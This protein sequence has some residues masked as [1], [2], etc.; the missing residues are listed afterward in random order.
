M[1][2]KIRNMIKKIGVVS[3][4]AAVTGV[5][6]PVA[7]SAF[8]AEKIYAEGDV[9][10]NET[11]F[12]DKIFREYVSKK[13]D[14]DSN[15]KLSDIE[16][17]NVK[18]I[19]GVYSDNGDT[20]TDL[21]GIEYFEELDTLSCNSHGLNSL[22]VSKNK[23]LK[24]LS[25]NFNTEL[26][27]LNISNNTLLTSLS[28]YACAIKELN[29]SNNPDLDSLMCHMNFLKSLDVSENNKL[30][31][32]CCDPDLEDLYISKNSVVSLFSMSSIGVFETIKS[33]NNNVAAVTDDLSIKGLDAG[34]STI[35][36]LDASGEVVHNI[37]L[38]VK[39]DNINEEIHDEDDLSAPDSSN[40]DENDET[41]WKEYWEAEKSRRRKM[42]FDNTMSKYAG[43]YPPIVIENE[44][45]EN[46]TEKTQIELYQIL[47]G[48]EVKVDS[49]IKEDLLLN[50]LFQYEETWTR[51]ASSLT[52]YRIDSSTPGFSVVNTYGEF[53][54]APGDY[55]IKCV[56]VPEGYEKFKD[57]KFT[58]GDKSININ[59]PVRGILQNIKSNGEKV[60]IAESNPDYINEKVYKIDESGKLTKNSDLSKEDVSMYGDITDSYELLTIVLGKKSAANNNKG[61]II[62]ANTGDNKSTGLYVAAGVSIAGLATTAAVLQKKRKNN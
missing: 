58:L 60:Y 4:L 14:K 9:E 7:F 48:K 55:V 53:Y 61:G 25:C 59:N 49:F 12:P 43:G 22:D 36:L 8:S 32:I 18:E 3:V 11:N 33:S 51:Y 27:E 44:S 41:Y 42:N 35:S 20:A 24:E 54:V 19:S 21:K 23:K 52:H 57:I 45:G 28:C 6:V 30:K 37:L 50:R 46:L 40:I 16:R 10:I 31:T 5:T 34:E 29:L 1:K 39:G 56:K 26:T 2:K 62:S 15:N 38:T 17:D 13:F 47:N